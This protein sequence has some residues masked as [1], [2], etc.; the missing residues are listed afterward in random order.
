[1][2]FRPSRLLVAAVAAVALAIGVGAAL[3]SDGDFQAKREAFMA[4]VAKRL[5]VSTEALNDAIKGARIAQVEQALKD[6][7]ITQ[8]QADAAKKAI[9]S[10]EGPGFGFGPGFGHRGFGGGF[11]PGPGFGH[12]GP[13]FAG[14]L[15]AAA[16]YLDLTE[17][18]LRTEL[19][20]GKS[21]ATIAGEKGKSVDGLKAAM[22]KDATAKLDEA[23]AAGRITKEQRDALAERLTAMVDRAVDRT[24]RQRGGGDDVKPAVFDGAFA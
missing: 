9:E 23:L 7:K 15:D 13:G 2:T 16:G 21:L 10:G 18:Q 4:D 14:G 1:M 20:S 17:E 6:G 8:E 5:G 24:P 3:A 12:H 22:V 19:Q 11:G